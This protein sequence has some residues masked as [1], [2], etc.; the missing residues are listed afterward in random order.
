MLLNSLQQSKFVC[1]S[2]K[3]IHMHFAADCNK[4]KKVGKLPHVAAQQL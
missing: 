1:Q 3:M 4:M 2:P